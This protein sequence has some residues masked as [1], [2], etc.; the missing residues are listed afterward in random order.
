MLKGQWA[1]AMTNNTELFWGYYSLL[2]FITQARVVL[3]VL[4]RSLIHSSWLNS[5][6]VLY[7]Q[8]LILVSRCFLA[9][10][11]GSYLYRSVS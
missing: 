6:F 11:A 5:P 8:T 1:Y 9:P 3:V 4:V 2:Q 10:T 7:A